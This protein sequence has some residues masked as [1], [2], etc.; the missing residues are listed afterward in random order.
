MNKHINVSDTDLRLFVATAREKTNLEL[1]YEIGQRYARIHKPGFNDSGRSV[2]CFVDLTNGNVLRPD[3][4]K[5]PN[6]KVKNSVRG[7]VHDE[8]NGCGFMRAGCDRV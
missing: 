3:G 1:G 5:R 4:W 6:L 8:H 2:F 7:N